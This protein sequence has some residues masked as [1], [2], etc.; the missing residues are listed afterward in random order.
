MLVESF[1]TKDPATVSLRDNLAQADAK[2]RKGNFRH[3]PVVD[4]NKLV[5]MLSDHDIREHVGHLKETLV[6][7]VMTQKLVIAGLHDP[8]EEAARTLLRLKIG[9]LPVVQAGR[10]AGILT[11]SDIVAAFVEILGFAEEDSVRIDLLLEPAGPHDLSSAT[12]IIRDFGAEVLGLGTYRARWEQE[13]VYY[14][15]VRGGSSDQI[16]DALTA[17]GFRVLGLH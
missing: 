4:G 14:L 3:L 10:L 13:Q 11:T 15:V 7:G 5:A 12:R 1:M 8:I 16:N 17:K 9:V 6:S 2:M